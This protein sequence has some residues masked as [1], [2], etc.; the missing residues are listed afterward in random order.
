MENSSNKFERIEAKGKEQDIEITLSN[1]DKISQF[2]SE[3]LNGN[4][5]K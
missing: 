1:S 2:L 5:I 3:K 4:Y